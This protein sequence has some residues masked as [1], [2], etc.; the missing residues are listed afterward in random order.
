MVTMRILVYVA[1]V[2]A[3]FAGAIMYGGNAI[4][5][6]DPLPPAPEPPPAVKISHSK[7]K[8]KGKPAEQPSAPASGPRRTAAQ[9]A[10]VKKTNA[11]CRDSK[12]E[13]QAVLATGNTSTP[14]GVL[15]LFRRLKTVNAEL[16]DRFLA[17]PA[18]AGYKDDVA[19]LRQLFA[20]EELYFDSM[21]RALQNRDM[22]R[23]YALNDRLTDIA[24]DET[25][26]LANLGAY[27]CDITLSSAFS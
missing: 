26:I 5:A 3:L 8:E 17:I 21:G 12:A 20:K 9:K 10:F 2:V 23:F 6:W 14:A 4:G 24:L 7:P 19:E 11:L 27:A 15:E 25:D 22:R 1:A 18:P 13:V 16:N